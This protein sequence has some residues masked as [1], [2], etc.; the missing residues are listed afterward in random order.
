MAHGLNAHT[1]PYILRQMLTY[2]GVIFLPFYV[3]TLVFA[4]STGSDLNFFQPI[5]IAVAGVYIVEQT[6]SVR[7]GGWKAILVSLA[8]VP[9]LLLNVFLNIVYIVTFMGVIFATDEAWGRM[10][11]LDA[12]SFD[13]NGRARDGQ[14]HRKLELHGTHALRKTPGARVFAASSITMLVVSLTLVAIIP[15]VSLQAA[16]NIIAVYV[17]IG[18]IATVGRLVPV[19]TF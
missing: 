19:T 5:W 15:L 18:A 14:N 11:H 2:L 6:F 10:R 9:E 16:W 1:A 17:L 3:Y 13:K 12:A 8:I 4:L 7:K